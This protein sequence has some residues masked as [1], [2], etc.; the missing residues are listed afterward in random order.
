MEPTRS[1][2]PATMGGVDGLEEVEATD[3]VMPIIRI[4]HT[5]G[6]FTDNL[7]N[8]EFESVDCVV[9]GL[10]K[11]RILWPAEP[12]DSGE[13]PLC[14]S[15]SFTTGVPNGDAWTKDVISAS[16]FSRTDVEEASELNCANCQLKEWGSHPKTPGPWCNEQYTFPLLVLRPDDDDE[17]GTMGASPAVISFQRTGIKPSKTYVSGFVQAKKP[18]YTAITRLT[19]SHQRKGTVEYSVPRF[20]KIDDTDPVDWARYSEAFASIR[21]FLKTPRTPVTEDDAGTPVRR[22]EA[23]A[24]EVADEVGKRT[25]RAT[26]VADDEEPF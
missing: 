4:N 17:T 5:A 9:L 19:L 26:P 20:A 14:R 22:G 10:V 21:D 16:G 7:T 25:V 6:M 15:Y 8:E 13:P 24:T 11:Q 1:A 18:L 3:L 23:E 2:P 12:G